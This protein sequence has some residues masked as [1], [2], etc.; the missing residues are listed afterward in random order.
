MSVLDLYERLSDLCVNVINAD[1]SPFEAYAEIVKLEKTRKNIGSTLLDVLISVEGECTE[2]TKPNFQKFALLL[3]NTIIPEDI[4]R[5]ELECFDALKQDVAKQLVRLKTRIYF[6]QSKFNLLREETEG[7]AK[8]ITELIE[9]EQNASENYAELMK[10]RVLSIIGQFNLD[11]NRVTDIILE[12]FEHCQK[13]KKFFINLLKKIQVVK[14]YLCAILGFKYSFYQGNNKKTPFSLYTLTAALIQNDMINT[15]KILAYMVPKT[16]AIKEGHRARMSNALERSSKAET[17]ATAQM[18]MD[19]RSIEEASGGGGA[20][21]TTISFTTVAQIQENDD[22]RLAEKFTEDY[23]LATNQKLG[24]ACALLESGNWQQAQTLIDRLPE[25]YAVQ[26]SA[27]L[28]RAL[29]KIVE[30][31]LQ[32]FYSKHWPKSVFADFLKRG[33]DDDDAD[34]ASAAGGGLLPI[35][36]WH[37]LGKLASVLWYLGPR[38]AYRATTC[39]KVLR[40]LTVYFRGNEKDEK[41]S[42]IFTDVVSECIL[43]SLTLAETN[44]ALSEEMWQLV[45]LFPYTWRYWM[46]A[47]WN[48]ETQRHPELNIMRGKIYGRTKYVLKRLSKETVRVMG[49]QLGK[50]CHVHPTTVLS[51]LLSQVQ[52]FDNLIGPVVDG[53]RF[54]TSL[55]FDVLTYCI[56]SQLADPSKQA[57]KSTDATI[58]PWLQ[59]LGTLVGSLYRRYPLELNGM[60]EYVQNQLKMCKSFDMLLLREIIQNMSW[61]ESCTQAT[62]DQLEALSGGEVLRQETSSATVPSFLGGSLARNGAKS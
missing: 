11:P 43:P 37:D 30:N 12:C 38:I 29:C 10:N 35:D 3:Q 19:A 6:K 14:E 22:A 5:C 45:Q 18:P 41:L 54:L 58:S 46:Y 39:V 25:Y 61:V 36:S 7:Y 52:T 59:A 40:L 27:R 42:R 62:R 56:I 21:T 24:L 55:E 4:L 47:K 28:C 32:P 2:A 20:P 51:Y 31:A 44:V 9:A 48:S 16:E 1:K 8:L 17:I 53:L 50:L 26:S 34:E 49:R 60:L 13:N 57:L 33:D 23:V 15:M